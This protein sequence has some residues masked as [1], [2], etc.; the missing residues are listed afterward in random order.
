VTAGNPLHR[1]PG[2]HGY[3]PSTNIPGTDDTHLGDRW[4]N[5]KTGAFTQPDPVTQVDDLHN[6]NAYPYAADNYTDPTGQSWLSQFLGAV[7]FE[8]VF[9][10][11]C[12]VFVIG[13]TEGAGSPLAETACYW[14]G[15]T[16]AGAYGLA[17][18]Q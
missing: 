6:A 18:G 9:T 7:T 5:P 13:I 17:A 2:R 16:L 4:L 10:V 15:S 12:S 14:A 8:L 11:T 3:S 1:R